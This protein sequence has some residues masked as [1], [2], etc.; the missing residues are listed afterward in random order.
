MTISLDSGS[1]AARVAER[2][3]GLTNEKHK[4]INQLLRALDPN[5]SLRV[6][7][8][9]DPA[10]R[11]PKTMGVYEENTQ[12]ASSPWVFTI[13]PEFVDERVVARVAAGDMTKTTP[14][15]RMEILRKV[16]QAKEQ[17]LEAEWQAKKEELV[18]QVRALSRT[19]GAVRHRINGETRILSDT[20]GGHS[21]RT[22]I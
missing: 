16:Q 21:P 20:P 15:E 6:I 12:G 3:Y 7:P 17:L 14:A 5:L 8:E 22:H 10:F 1:A 2:D 11:P 13:E 18:E 9:R 4:R 19:H